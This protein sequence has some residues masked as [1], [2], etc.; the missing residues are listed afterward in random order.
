MKSKKYTIEPSALSNKRDYL[1]IVEEI[2][3]LYKEEL[4]WVKQGRRTAMH[5]PDVPRAT[6]RD[7]IAR[8]L[9]I[10]NITM[11]QLLYIDKHT[12]RDR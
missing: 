10:S 9:R 7:L 12:R 3:R 11:A 5:D 6:K 1:K 4:D 8:A 2:K